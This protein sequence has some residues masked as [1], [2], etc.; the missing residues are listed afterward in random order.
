M[1][2]ALLVI[3]SSALVNN[4]VLMK[5]LGLCPFMGV[6]RQ[7]NAALG[8]GIATTFVL[9][10][11]S[12]SSTIINQFLL[13]PFDLEFLRT[14]VFIVIIAIFVQLTEILLRH[15]SPLLH[16]SL[17]IYLPLITTNCAVLGVVL[18]NAQAQ[19]DW[20]Q[21]ILYSFGAALGFA[22]V[23]VLF[24]GVREQLET[25]D[26]P[27]PFKGAPIALITAGLMSVAFMGFS[28]LIPY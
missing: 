5:F 15:T 18:L 28:G 20:L 8:M 27:E 14:I 23:L 6:S 7:S 25:A 3:I 1:K 19:H 12:V 10:L 24:A 22:L 16:R 26:V 13:I 4:F 11:A 21:S 9:I 2:E 17:G